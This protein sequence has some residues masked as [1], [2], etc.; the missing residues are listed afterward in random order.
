MTIKKTVKNILNSALTLILSLILLT[1]FTVTAYAQKETINDKKST[2]VKADKPASE[3]K[4]KPAPDDPKKSPSDDSKKEAKPEID[5][6]KPEVW[7]D[8]KKAEKIESTL[9]YGMQKE[10]KIAIIMINDIKDEQIKK[11]LIEKLVYIISN[12]SDIEVRKA[13]VTAIGDH[14]SE[15]AAPA[16]IKALD[17][18]EDDIKIA[19]CYALGRIKAESAKTK[20][21][22]LLK[23]QDLKKDSNLTDAIITT[24]YE[25]KSPDILELAVTSARDNTTSRMIRERLIIYIGNTGSAAQKDFLIELFKN[26]EEEAGIRSYAIKSIAKLKLKEAAPEI[27]EIIKEI[28]SYSFAKKKKYYDIYMQAVAALVEM[29]DTDSIGLLMNSLR[30]DNTAVRLKAVNLIKEFNDERTIDILKYKMKNDPDARIRKTAR[31]ALEE[32][33]LIEKGKEDENQRNDFE[34]DEKNDK[35]E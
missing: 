27:K 5:S 34:K 4:N 15:S 24:L 30:S 10:R 28:D 9:E 7:D 14:K 23:K 22:E 25:I 35:D 20:L 32:K 33:G 26:D 16:L 13:A 2:T 17:D 31:K 19:A 18:E 3:D 6:K 1:A 8:A 21:I 11:K 12:D 29:G